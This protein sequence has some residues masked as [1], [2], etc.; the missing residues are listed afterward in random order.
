MRYIIENFDLRSLLQCVK[1]DGGLVDLM[2]NF[3]FGW[4]VGWMNVW[5][6]G[7]MDGWL[8]G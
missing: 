6:V 4:L 7:W 8:V 2:I 5:L 3:W 1:V